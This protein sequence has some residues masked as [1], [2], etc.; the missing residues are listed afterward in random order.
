MKL[1]T[2]AFYFLFLRWILLMAGGAAA[3]PA[4]SGAASG[5]YVVVTG[6]ADDSLP[7]KMEAAKLSACKEALLMVAP[8]FVE[9]RSVASFHELV[10]S[11]NY[12]EVRGFIEEAVPMGAGTSQD[13][14]YSRK[15]RIKV[16]KGDLNLE[17]WKRKVDIKFLYDAAAR[18][19]LCLAITDVDSAL[20]GRGGLETAVAQRSHGRI[21][22]YFRKQHPDFD[23]KDLLLLRSSPDMESDLVAEANKNS[24][25][26]LIYGTTKKSSARSPRRP[27]TGGSVDI[28]FADTAIWEFDWRVID[29]RNRRTLFHVQTPGSG[30]GL[31]PAEQDSPYPAIDQAAAELFREL[32]VQWSRSATG[33]KLE[34]SFESFEPP[35]PEALVSMLK[36]VNGLDPESIQLAS[37]DKSAVIYTISV[38][39]TLPEIISSLGKVFQ[40][41]YKIY[42]GD[43]GRVRLT[44]VA[45]IEIA[46]TIKGASL[47]NLGL[48]QSKLQASPDIQSVRRQNFNNGVATLLLKT[49]TSPEEIGKFLEKILPNQLI[50]RGETSSTLDAEVK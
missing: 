4:P 20:S 47:S 41:D 3:Q 49:Y 6:R 13:N 33:R 24:F 29:V 40:K 10:S 8:V 12:T 21:I 46:I 18:P 42:S 9:A 35:N 39:R 26:I 16:N 32:L 2:G 31:A 14:V 28:G 22:S 30:G 34:V 17:L 25:D 5:D 36:Q 19:R 11:Y 27:Y 45:A 23:F 15:Y 43:Q 38:T 44:A 50:V 37:L 1:K 48:I 7:D